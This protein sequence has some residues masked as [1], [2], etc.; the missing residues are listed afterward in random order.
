M[1]GG[2][3]GNRR[4]RVGRYW[5]IKPYEAFGNR[6]EELYFALLKCRRDGL[7][8]IILKRKWDLFGRVRF[9]SANKALLNIRH[10]SVVAHPALEVVNYLMTIVLSVSRIIGIGL[11]RCRSLLGFQPRNNWLVDLSD[12]VFG[13]AGLW[14]D[15]KVPFDV[16][17]IAIDWG[18]ELEDKLNVQYQ[19]RGELER[20]F[21]ALKDRKYVCLHVR[22]GGFFD[23][24]EYSSP[25]NANINNYIPALRE[26]TDQGYLVARLGDPA[27]PPFVMDQVLDYAHSPLRSD[28]NDVRLIEHCEFYIGSLSGPIDTA[29][30]FEKR[31]LTVN[32]LSMAHC[33][34][35]RTGARF[36]PKR[37]LRDKKLLT[38][39]E[40]ID[41]HLFEILGTGQ[42][43]EGVEYQENTAD[44]ILEAVREF[45]ASPSLSA[46]QV[47]FNEYLS[48]RMVEYFETVRVWDKAEDDAGQKTRW[49]SRILAAQGSVC[50]G[51]LKGHWQ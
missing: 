13:Q 11:R 12:K 29:C 38:L 26:L 37:A 19:S 39:K 10:P 34:W 45:L 46:E 31:I 20:D 43:V 30:L 25:R 41:Q 49:A 8:L 33:T 23:D 14:G 15:V 40:Q 17:N 1:A 9:R 22:T 48:R 32:C 24:H 36:I 35:Y 6:A 2:A 51:Y 4:M 18:R 21:P 7:R 44:D 50:A 16:K 42:M 27:M 47:A 5:I 3:F 28:P